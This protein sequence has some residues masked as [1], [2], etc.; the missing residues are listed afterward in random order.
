MSCANTNML[1]HYQNFQCRIYAIIYVFFDASLQRA[2]DIA[3]VQNTVVTSQIIKYALLYELIHEDAM[4]QKHQDFLNVYLLDQIH[5]NQ[6]HCLDGAFALAN[7]IVIAYQF[8][9]TLLQAGRH[10]VYQQ[11][12]LEC[13]MNFVDLQQLT[14]L[15]ASNITVESVRDAPKKRYMMQIPPLDIEF[16]HDIDDR[17]QSWNAETDIEHIIFSAIENNNL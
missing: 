7:E 2:F 11:I 13:A 5:E 6:D 15:G 9:H 3:E 14:L 1:Q 16:L 4:I 12:F 17:I 8:C 10:R